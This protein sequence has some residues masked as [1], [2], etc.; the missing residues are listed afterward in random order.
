VTEHALLWSLALL[1]LGTLVMPQDG[2]MEM[3]ATFFGGASPQA[4]QDLELRLYKNNVTPSDTDTAATFTQSDF[5][6]YAA[7]PLARGAGWTLVAGHPSS[8]GY[9]Q[10]TFASDAAQA[11]QQAY[12]YYVVGASSGKLAWAER[13]GT[14]PF[15]IGNLGDEVLVTPNFTQAGGG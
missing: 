14:G 3:L 15:P 6:G 1:L 8:A 12:G 2:E 13:F 5:S 10:Q 7:V 9:A 4:V 11:V